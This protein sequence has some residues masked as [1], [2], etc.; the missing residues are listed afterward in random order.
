M[1]F[2]NNPL[3]LKKGFVDLYKDPTPKITTR[4]VALLIISLFFFASFIFLNDESWVCGP[5]CLNSIYIQYIGYGCIIP[6]LGH[7]FF[8]IFFTKNDFNY[9]K[10]I[11]DQSN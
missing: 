11:K 9:W 7:T 10:K 4:R 1:F 3:F 5:I 6:V 8:Q 2:K